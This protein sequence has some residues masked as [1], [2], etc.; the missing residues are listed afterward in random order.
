MHDH[1]YNIWPNVDLWWN[2]QQ[3]QSVI[4]NFLKFFSSPTTK[5]PL[6]SIKKKITEKIT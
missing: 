1:I 3:T 6:R 4:K 5:S 2:S